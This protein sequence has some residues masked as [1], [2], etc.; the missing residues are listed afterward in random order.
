MARTAT[1]PITIH[2]VTVRVYPD[3]PT[4]T[5]RIRWQRGAVPLR[6]YDG[7]VKPLAV[8]SAFR[9]GMFI[10]ALALL[11][12]MGFD[13]VWGAVFATVITFA[14]SIIFLGS[15]RQKAADALRQRVEKPVPD[16]DTAHEDSQIAAAQRAD[17]DD[18]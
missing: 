11:L 4:A 16:T 6:I 7:N 13:W 8:Y 9:L 17:H 3:G 1:I 12:L 15:L 2:R 14:L 18:E 10:V 5:G